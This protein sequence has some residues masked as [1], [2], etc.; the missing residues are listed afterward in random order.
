MILVSTGLHM[1]AA[2]VFLVPVFLIWNGA[3]LHNWKKCSSYS[4]LSLYLAAVY[5]L[6]GMPDVTYIRFELNLNVIPVVGIVT[7]LRSSLL[8]VLL[9]VP[10]GL[11]L[12]ILWTD[13]RDRKKTLLFGLGMSCAIEIL[14]IFTF[15]ATDINDLITNTAGTCLGFL[16]ADILMKKSP[17]IGELIK[18]EKTKDLYAVCTA[19]LGVMFFLEPFVFSLLWE[20]VF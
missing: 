6:V 2:A 7:D 13:F 15:R 18:E 8:N 4:L 16:M 5:T 10:L 12:P 11:L 14:Q 9:F 19:T 3:G 1:L 20:I 17:A